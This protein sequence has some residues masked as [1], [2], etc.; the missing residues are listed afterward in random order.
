MRKVFGLSFFVLITFLSTLQVGITSCTKDKTIYD[1]ITKKDTIIK[2]DTVIRKDTTVTMEIL[3]ANPWKVQEIRGVIGNI[4][5]YYL[6]GGTTNTPGFALDNE[7]ITF[8]SDHTGLYVDNTTKSYNLT[9]DFANSEKTKI[10]YT[11][12]NFGGAPSLTINWEH[13]AY[14]NAS[15]NY[16]EYYTQGSYQSHSHGQ[17]IPK[18]NR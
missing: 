8:N 9:W 7:Y 4:Y 15:L 17:R 14:K 10:T 12:F 18:G 6:R 13:L 2:I 5:Y 16:D 1:T 3:T 11:M